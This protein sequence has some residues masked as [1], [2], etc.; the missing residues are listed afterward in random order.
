MKS[1]IEGCLEACT[2]SDSQN[3]FRML[4]NQFGK[5][6]LELSKDYENSQ[7]FYALRGIV[8]FNDKGY[9]RNQ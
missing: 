2:E 6:D 4:I 1:I 8:L 5:N 7:I 3:I 9:H